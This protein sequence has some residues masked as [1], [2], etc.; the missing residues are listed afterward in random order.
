[1]LGD[2]SWSYWEQMGRGGGRGR[3]VKEEEGRPRHGGWWG[4]SWERTGATLTQTTGVL[5]QFFSNISFVG[6]PS[7]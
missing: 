1:M 3:E 5:T 7:V 4:G 2:V 6:S